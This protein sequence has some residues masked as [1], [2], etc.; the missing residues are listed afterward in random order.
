MDMLL[1]TEMKALLKERLPE[2]DKRSFGKLA[3]LAGST[4]MAGAAV[5][6]G[7]AAMRTGVGLGTFLA[8][9]ETF[10][11]LQTACPE[12]TCLDRDAISIPEVLTKG[13]FSAL[14]LGPGLG[15]P[16]TKPGFFAYIKADSMTDF[17]DLEEIF[18]DYTGPIVLDADGL[19]ALRPMEFLDDFAAMKAPKVI[20]PHEREA[21]RLM[22]V[23]RIEGREEAVRRLAKGLDCV[24][25]LKGHH[26]LIADPLGQVFENPTGNV[27]LATGGTGDVLAGMIGSLL[28]QGYTALDA[29]RLGVYLHGLAGDL[30][31]DDKGAAG[32]IAS[33]VVD[34]IPAALRALGE[35]TGEKI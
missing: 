30:A 7:R 27:G 26:T 29:A 24:A 18:R 25:V 35:G 12:C 1:P 11:V 4:G 13:H 32:M 16:P 2:H 21:A 31:A 6:C 34:K 28:A 33:D 8:A 17:S 15:Q 5:L 22:G 20:T 19:N 10:P 3:I 23:E 14:V 9:G